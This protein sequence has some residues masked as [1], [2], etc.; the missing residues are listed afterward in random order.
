MGYQQVVVLD[1]TGKITELPTALPAGI[2]QTKADSNK[3]YLLL[4]NG[5]I[6]VAE[7]K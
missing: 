6:W 3:A 5:E 2:K 4:K 1:K 7:E